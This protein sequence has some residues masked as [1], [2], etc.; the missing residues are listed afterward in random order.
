MLERTVTQAPRHQCGS[1]GLSRRVA[2]VAY[3]VFGLVVIPSES[4]GLFLFGLVLSEPGCAAE[5]LN[6]AALGCGAGLSD[7]RFGVGV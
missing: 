1:T 2:R 4:R 3:W 6:E 7:R 5:L